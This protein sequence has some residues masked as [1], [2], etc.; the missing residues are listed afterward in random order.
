MCVNNITILLKNCHIVTFSTASLP[1]VTQEH[2]SV[3]SLSTCHCQWHMLTNVTIVIP[4]LPSSV[5]G[6]NIITH[7]H[8]HWAAVVSRGWA[9]APSCRLQIHCPV[10]CG[11]LPYRVAPVY[12]Q[13]VSPPLS[14]SPLSSFLVILSP[15]GNT[16]GPSVVF[17]AG[18]MPCPGPFHF[19]YTVDCIYDFCPLPDSDV[20]L[21]IFI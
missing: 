3:L 16:R 4:M 17:E 10:L 1:A 20:G 2:I 7:H 18:D 11:P 6:D 5:Y 15:C 14:W 8:H 21:S 19:S 12:V 13:V 9:K